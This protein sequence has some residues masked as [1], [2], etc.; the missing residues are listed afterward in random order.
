M[1]RTA[2]N[3]RDRSE[4]I[5]KATFA[6]LD[7][8]AVAVAMGSLGATM[9]WVATATLL[10]KGAPEGAHIGEHLGLLAHFFPGYS[11]TWTGSIVGALYGF[12]VGAACGASVGVFW[13]FVH[14]VVLMAVFRRA[15]TTGL[16]I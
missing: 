2:D 3:D 4:R 10:V 14:Y 7:I 9:L 13:N 6:R 8:V 12:V 5:V 16:D 11:V 15:P 1:T